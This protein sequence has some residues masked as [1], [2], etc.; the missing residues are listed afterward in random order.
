GEFCCG[1]VQLDGRG[2][3]FGRR[4]GLLESPISGLECEFVR[5]QRIG[6]FAGLRKL[7]LD[8]WFSGNAWLR[9]GFWFCVWFGLWLRAWFGRGSG[10]GIRIRLWLRFR[11]R[12]RIGS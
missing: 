8:F 11:L 10:I 2:L 4:G 7:K 5:R 6:R 12:I 1:A 9:F 3:L